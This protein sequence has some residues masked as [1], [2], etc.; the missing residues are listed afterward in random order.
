VNGSTRVSAQNDLAMPLP[1]VSTID[2]LSRA[3]SGKENWQFRLAIFDGR[4]EKS[5]VCGHN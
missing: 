4:S 3:N 2:V 1:Q 5:F